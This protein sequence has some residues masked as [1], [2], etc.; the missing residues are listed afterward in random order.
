MTYF[1]KRKAQVIGHGTPPEISEKQKKDPNFPPSIFL[2][3]S[4]ASWDADSLFLASM[5]REAELRREKPET[6]VLLDIAFTANGYA[7]FD[8]SLSREENEDR[9][10]KEETAIRER[11]RNA[12]ESGA[13]I[14]TLRFGKLCG[15]ATER[16]SVV[17][18]LYVLGQFQR[19]GL[20]KYL[21]RE[22]RG[23]IPELRVM[24]PHATYASYAAVDFL[25]QA[26]R[27]E[28]LRVHIRESGAIEALD[29]VLRQG[30]HIA[31]LRY[32]AEDE[33]YYLR[34]C[35]R[36]GLRQEPIMEFSYLLLTSQDSPLARRQ[37]RELDELNDYIEVLHGDTHLPG[38]ESTVSR[39][40]VNPNRRIHVYERCSQFSILQNLPTAYMWSSPMP[41]RALE[42]YHLALHNCPAQKQ[43][44]R[45]VL[46]YP[47]REPL[48]PEEQLFVQLLHKQADATIKDSGWKKI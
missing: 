17:E 46:V 27:S 13:E 23:Q 47:E 35:Q 24:I 41:Q 43:Q 16:N 7:A 34:Y 25:Q 20:A 40:E 44:M 6:E 8:Y 31:L 4:N 48:Q 11:I 42:Q 38:E 14:Y 33:D 30:Y 28:Q 18:N 29:F 5:G 45:D 10:R 15:F 12:L 32:A 1:R 37:V 36:H 22:L 21:L 3:F 26:A 9:R 39:W 2:R 19:L